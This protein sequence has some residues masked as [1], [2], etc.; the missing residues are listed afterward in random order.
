MSSCLNFFALWRSFRA[1]DELRGVLG[2]FR[3]LAFLLGV[4]AMEE[5][6]RSLLD[7]LADFDDF[8][9][10]GVFLPDDVS[11]FLV[12]LDDAA[13]LDG[14]G[15]LRVESDMKVGE[16]ADESGVKKVLIRD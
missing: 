15:F 16:R 3:S 11:L 14:R 6:L 8:P 13:R 9:P 7:F 4:L 12:L 10:P 1:S 5:D 2:D